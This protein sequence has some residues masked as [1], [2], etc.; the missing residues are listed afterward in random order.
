MPKIEKAF[1]QIYFCLIVVL[2]AWNSI[3]TIRFPYGIDYGE[4]P[5]M[6][7]VVRIER[8]ETLYKANLAEPPYVIANYPPVYPAW[9]AVMNSLLKIPLFLAGRITAVFFSIVSGV[10]VGLFSYRLT[11]DKWIGVLSS[12]LFL[13]MPFVV[14]WSSLARVDTMALAF[15][16][17]GL[18]ILYLHKDKPMW[19]ALAGVCFLVSIFTRQTY[20][21]A[22]PLAGFIWLWNCNRW[23]A[24]IFILLLFAAGLMMFE[25]I[26]V[27][28]GGGFYANIV[29]AN[30]NRYNLA[31]ALSKTKQFLTVWLLL[32]LTGLAA[33]AWS[34]A[35]NIK[36]AD[37]AKGELEQQPFLTSGLIF[38]TLG[39]AVSA[40]TIVKIGS[41]I[42]YFLELIAA[43]A[44]WS[45]LGIKL[46]NK[47]K[48]LIKWLAL[49]LLFFQF[50][51]ISAFSYQIINNTNKNFWQRLDLYHDLNTKIQAASQSGVVLSDDYMD[52]IVLAGQR[53]Y[54][55]PFEYGELYYAGEWDPTAFAAQIEMREFPLIVIGGGTLNKGCC[56]PPSVINATDSN[57][58]AETIED[59][60]IY[61]PLK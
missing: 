24:M 39:A 15:G 56:W 58:Q 17:L 6:D 44:I 13:G 25:I 50:A 53:I 1:I 59:V 22:A 36:P 35:T 8:R 55:Q 46:I 60:L 14:F 20:I 29:T 43:C 28:S 40:A 34:I 30:I 31:A 9:V 45:G 42:N 4:A 19:M 54:Y 49:G 3:L 37:N 23:R 33:I 61:T 26:N 32:I 41:N 11:R 5:L 52:M 16:L 7:Q 38:Y 51:W 18:Y 57:Y 47:Q 2:F 48:N 21:L 10:L 27:A 12:A